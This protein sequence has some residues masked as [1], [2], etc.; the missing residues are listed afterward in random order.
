MMN[1]QKLRAGRTNFLAQIADQQ[2]Y[3]ESNL[4]TAD[5]YHQHTVITAIREFSAFAYREELML[6]Q[7]PASKWTL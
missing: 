3:V 4:Q 7:F 2:S 6:S 5:R 1:L